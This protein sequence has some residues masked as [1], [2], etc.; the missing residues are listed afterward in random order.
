MDNADVPAALE[1]AQELIKLVESPTLV[2]LM[3]G[4]VGDDVQIR[5]IALHAYPPQS[6]DDARGGGYTGW[7]RCA[8]SVPSLPVSAF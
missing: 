7:H 1:R 2:P 4:M 5:E 3:A 6:N 8:G